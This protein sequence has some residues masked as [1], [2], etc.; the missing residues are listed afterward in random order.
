MNF[1]NKYIQYMIDIFEF[2]KFDDTLGEY[3]NTAILK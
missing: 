2:F 1:L 3:R